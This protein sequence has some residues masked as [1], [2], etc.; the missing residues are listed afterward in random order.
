MTGIE[1]RP[2]AKVEGAHFGRTA[3]SNR[4]I[5]PYLARMTSN[6]TS[7]FAADDWAWAVEAI[8][9]ELARLGPNRHAE[10]AQHLAAHLGYIEVDPVDERWRLMAR[11][12]ARVC[13]AAL[14]EVA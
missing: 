10:V 4:R 2:R 3:E 12:A 9:E 6:E 7:E 1:R 14:D 11:L 5:N 8:A 13:D